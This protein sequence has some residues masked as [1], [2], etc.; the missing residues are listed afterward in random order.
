LEVE[1]WGPRGP[2]IRGNPLYRCPRSR[3]YLRGGATRAS[4]STPPV[5]REGTRGSARHPPDIRDDPPEPRGIA[6]RAP[7]P[8]ASRTQAAG[9]PGAHAGDPEA[10]RQPRCRAGPDRAAA[11]K[12]QPPR[13]EPAQGGHERAV[14]NLRPPV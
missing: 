9:R 1:Q 13:D 14:P 8:G 5:Y 2:G 4:L 6:Q 7:D 10:G 11:A 12:D 3:R